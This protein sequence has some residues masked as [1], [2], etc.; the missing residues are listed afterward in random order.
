MQYMIGIL[1]LN[2]FLPSAGNEVQSLVDQ[3]IE[4]LHLEGQE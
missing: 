2:G 1:A 3:G 4:V